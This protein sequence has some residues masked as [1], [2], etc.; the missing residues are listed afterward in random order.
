MEYAE[1]MTPDPADG[2]RRDVRAL[3]EQ[4]G[5][6]ALVELTTFI[7]LANLYTPQQRR[8]RHRVARVRR[9]PC[10]LAPLATRPAY[11]STA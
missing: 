2:H 4:L 1:A 9:R 11:A 5:P 3:L 6:A 7:A 8:A 10:D